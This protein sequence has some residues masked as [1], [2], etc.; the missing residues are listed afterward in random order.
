MIE[1]QSDP[2]FLN[3]DRRVSEVVVVSHD[4]ATSI[5]DDMCEKMASTFE[6]GSTIGK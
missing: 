1:Q 3:P 2:G 6:A 4:V 5:Y